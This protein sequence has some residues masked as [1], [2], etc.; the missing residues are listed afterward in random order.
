MQFDAWLMHAVHA[1]QAVEWGGKKKILVNTNRPVPV[2]TDPVS[3]IAAVSTISHQL[4]C[5]GMP[6]HTF[7]R[8]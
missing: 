2:I 8:C 3:N 7:L 5:S 6:L 4:S 1:W